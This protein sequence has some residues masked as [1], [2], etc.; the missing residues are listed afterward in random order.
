[1][2]NT[3]TSGGEHRGAHALERAGADEE[4]DARRG[5]AQHG[6]TR[7]PGDAD[8]EH[9]APTEPV[10]QR[11]AEKQEAGERQRVRVDH[12]LQARQTRVEVLADRRQRD[13]HDGR[14]E[15]DHQLGDRDEYQRGPPLWIGL[16]LRLEL[17][18]DHVRHNW[19]H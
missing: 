8:E 10:T 4:L 17:G 11:A 13:V 12:P 2:V 3:E 5:R 1:M 16:E 6:G 14:V 19:S 7:E 15:D 9:A 18:L